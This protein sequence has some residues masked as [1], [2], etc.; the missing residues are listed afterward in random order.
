MPL[1]FILSGVIEIFII[2]NYLRFKN[3]FTRILTMLTLFFV[4]LGYFVGQVTYVNILFNCYHFLA[5]IFCVILLIKNNLS[6]VNLISIMII[7]LI[8]Y[9]L[10]INSNFLIGYDD[11]FIRFV[12]LIL[13]LLL[14]MNLFK[15]I[16]FILYLS[17]C[18]TLISGLQGM[19]NFMIMQIDLVFVFEM[20]Y[21]FVITYFIKKLFKVL[22]DRLKRNYYEKKNF[23]CFDFNNYVQ[24]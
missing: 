7:S 2:S 17:T 8:Y 13:S 20:V 5:L 16:N 15:G 22:V 21:I 6:I 12:F 23:D 10:N 19:N 3:N 11:K 18:I 14:S 24:H 9:L 4:M 1:V